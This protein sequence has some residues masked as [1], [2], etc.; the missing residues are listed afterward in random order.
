[1]KRKYRYRSA[2]DGRFVSKDYAAANPDTT[3]RELI[4]PKVP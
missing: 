4:K 2:R 1:M 3:I